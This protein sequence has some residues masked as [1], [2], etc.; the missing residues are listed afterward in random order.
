RARHLSER[1]LPPRRRGAAPQLWRRSRRRDLGDGALA[2]G[3]AAVR[4]SFFKFDFQTAYSVSSPAKAGDPVFQ[5]QSC[6][7]ETPLE[8]WMPRLKRGMTAEDGVRVVT[9]PLSRRA[10]RLRPPQMLVKPRHDFHEIAGARAVVELRVK[11][12]V[13]RV[14]AGAGRARQAEDERRVRNAG[15]G[16]ALDRRRSDLG[17]AQHVEGDG[18]TI[19]ALLEQR[20]DR[21]GRDVAAGKAGAAGRDDDVDALI[22]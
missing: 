10:L 8:Y 17:V 5:R 7:T 11:N 15:G 18:K 22:R 2:S 1:R 20:L 3:P 4:P 14:A 16:A 13:P 6:L 9:P 12:A 19:H 21:L